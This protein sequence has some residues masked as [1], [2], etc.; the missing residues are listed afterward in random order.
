MKIDI[1]TPDLRNI[2]EEHFAYVDRLEEKVRAYEEA[3]DTIAY[4]STTCNREACAQIAQEALY[5][6]ED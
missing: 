6:K 2:A 5:R 4:N 3:L 1:P